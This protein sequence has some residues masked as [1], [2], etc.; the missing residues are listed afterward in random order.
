MKKILVVVDMQNGFAI[1]DQTINLTE[2]I[3]KLL[4]RKLF[5]VVIATRFINDDNSI[6]E[7]LFGWNR[8]KTKEER[9]LADGY[10]KYVD[11]VLDKS[12]YT[13]VNSSFIQK[14]CQ[15]NDGIYPEEVFI[16][17]ADTDCCVLAIATGLFEC[18][19]RPI[20][21]TKYC[22]SNGG[23]A[24]HNAGL[25]CMKRLIGE[26]QLVDREILLKEDLNI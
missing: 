15:L 13:C 26:N 14:L 3:R 20:V 11:C 16:V 21:L 22:D 24:S 4:K 6:Y 9:E 1:Y 23:T 7:K 25:L 5:D 12:V 8:L 19:I 17:G 10:E 18:N 2:E